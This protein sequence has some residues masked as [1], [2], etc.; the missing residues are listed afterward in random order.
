MSMNNKIKVIHKT[1]RTLQPIG[2]IVRKDYQFGMTK[3]N[4]K[5]NFAR[6][7]KVKSGK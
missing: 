2:K 6:F 1:T 4:N 5:E 3:I 7:K